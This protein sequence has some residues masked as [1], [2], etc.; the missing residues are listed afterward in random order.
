RGHAHAA[1][2]ELP[3]IDAVLARPFV[4]ALEDQLA[5][6]T[7]AR[8]LLVV[9]LAVAVIAEPQRR[10]ER[11]L[12]LRLLPQLQPRIALDHDFT[13][14]V[15]IAR[16]RHPRTQGVAACA[17]LAS[18]LDANRHATRVYDLRRRA[19]RPLGSRAIPRAGLRTRW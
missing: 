6:Q 19:P 14:N 1:R 18:R 4:G 12:R 8:R 7:V 15:R 3:A 16:D 11:Q 10:L 13:S 9:V 5:D 17:R 2:E